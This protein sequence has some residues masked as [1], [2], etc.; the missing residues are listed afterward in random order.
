M[1]MLTLESKKFQDVLYNLR[2]ENLS[3]S[4]ELQLKIIEVVNSGK[5][6]TPEIIKG[7]VAD[8]KI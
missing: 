2:L 7:I 1:S 8:G 3:I 5:T 4:T 6:I